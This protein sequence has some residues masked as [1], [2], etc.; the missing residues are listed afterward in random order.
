M[1]RRKIQRKSSSETNPNNPDRMYFSTYN[2]ATGQQVSTY[3]DNPESAATYIQAHMLLP[4]DFDF[5]GS[6]ECMTIVQHAATLLTKGCNDYIAELTALLILGHSPCQLAL[7]TL[8][9]CSQSHYPLADVA[10]L[11]LFECSANIQTTSPGVAKS[12]VA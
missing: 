4:P 9:R 12:A 11:A 1:S 5:D 2:F 6:E 8:T 10:E 7:E 3:T